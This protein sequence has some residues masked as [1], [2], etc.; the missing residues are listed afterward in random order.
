M[1][2][3]LT[4]TLLALSLLSGCSTGKAGAAREVTAFAGTIVDDKMEGIHILTCNPETGAFRRV[5]ILKGVN[6]TTYFAINRAGTKLYSMIADPARTGA[7]NGAIVCYAIAGD[8]L[9]EV[10]RQAI[11]A[12]V[13]CYIALDH[14]ERALVWADYGNA[15]AGVTALRPDG[16][17]DTSIAP[18]AVQHFGCGP[19]KSRQEKAHAHCAAL[20]PDNRFLG[21]TDLGMDE[22]FFYDF[23]NWRSGLREVPQLT[24]HTAPGAGPRHF[25]F[26]PNGKLMFL[27]NELNNTVSSYR[28]DGKTFTELCTRS[29][30]PAGFTAFSKCAAIKLST[31]GS[32]LFASNRG[33]DSIAIFAVDAETGTLTLRRIAKLAGKFPRD[34]ELMPGERFM[35]VGHKMSDEIVSYAF[36][37]RRATLKPVFGPLSVHRPL[38]FKFIDNE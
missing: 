35:L 10:N 26:H 13:P 15:I 34:F 5:G 28:Y 8:T 32:L 2:K 7:F 20:T 23:A 25:V 31:D 27:I 14:Q 21:V 18:V 19:D 1:K 38:C 3:N 11:P 37:R 30:L 16:G 36:D 17:I 9:R 4:L 33:H 29:T 24:I 22:V 12:G 6:G